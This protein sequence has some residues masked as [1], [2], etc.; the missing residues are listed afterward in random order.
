MSAPSYVPNDANRGARVYASPPR[1]SGSWMA[2]RP[3]ELTGRQP[4]GVRL[5]SPGPDQGFVLRIAQRLADALV[6]GDGEHRGDAVAAVSA[7][8]LKR[9]SLF[10]RAPVVHDVRAAIEILGFGANASS[11]LADWRRVAIEE[12]HHPHHYPKLRAIAD[13]VPADVLHRPLDA[14]VA[15]ARA[16]WRHVIVA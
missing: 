11:D 1:R 8:A 10:G 3:G 2:D 6:L 4:E 14:I 5:G 12:A 9:A 16:D 7:V 15:D 13:A